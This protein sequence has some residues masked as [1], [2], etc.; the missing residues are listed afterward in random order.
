[1]TAK[2]N[3]LEEMYRLE[4]ENKLLRT[5]LTNSTIALDD[6]LRTFA[7]DLC[8]K[9]HVK[10]SYAR[11]SQNGGT[12]AYIADLQQANRNALKPK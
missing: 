2:T 4:K 10:E 12:L 9:E 7:Y 3:E 1:M 8:R 11:I 6:W 5:A